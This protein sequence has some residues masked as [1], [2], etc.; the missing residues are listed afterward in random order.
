MPCEGLFEFLPQLTE[1][2]GYSTNVLP[3][4][5]RRGSWEVATAPALAIASGWSRDSFGAFV[6]VQDT[7]YL[8]V[9]SQDR[10][11]AA[12]SIGGRLDIGEDKLTLAAAHLTQHEE[13]GALDTIASD[14][15]IAMHID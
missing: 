8:G 9:P 4:P 13:R 6:S 5:H 14:R 11:D 3:G 12:A 1:S 10:T 15:P 7:R 2:M